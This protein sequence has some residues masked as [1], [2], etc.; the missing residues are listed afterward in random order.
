[1]KNVLP[2]FLL[3]ASTAAAQSITLTLDSVQSFL[4]VQGTVPAIAPFL[5]APVTSTAQIAGSDLANYSGTIG[6]TLAPGSLTFDTAALDAISFGSGLLPGALDADYGT[7]FDLGFFGTAYVAV[8]SI[9]AS[10]SSGALLLSGD[11]FA[12]SGSFTFTSG[13][14]DAVFLGNNQSESLVGVS[15]ANSA[16]VAGS[17]TVTGLDVGLILP[18]R[19]TLT[20]N[21]VL[22]GFGSVPVTYDI[23]GVLVAAGTVPEASTSALLAGVSALAGVLWLRRRR[24]A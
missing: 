22:P 5:P 17:L 4:Q 19:T 13:V 20:V 8:R 23:T 6:I 2:A 11:N 14:V 3:A 7:Q 1:M 15:A 10:L 12:P 9:G 21:A 16:P 18:V 24:V